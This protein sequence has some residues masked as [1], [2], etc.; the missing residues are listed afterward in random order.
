MI[1]ALTETESQDIKNSYIKKIPKKP[2]SSIF[3]DL[4]FTV[5]NLSSHLMQITINVGPE[6]VKNIYNQTIELYREN[7]TILEF[8][9]NK[10]PAEYIEIK[11][12]NEVF[13]KIK[14]FIFK[15]FVFDFLIYKIKELKISIANYPRLIR[16][17]KDNDFNLKFIF[18]LS[19]AETVSLKEWK[20]FIFRPPKR[21]KYK[22]LDKQVENFIKQESMINKKQKTL[23]IEEYDWVIF[24]ATLLD[25]NNK[26][27]WENKKNSF[28]I[29]INSKNL[30]CSFQKT[31]IGKNIDDTFITTNMP[32]EEDSLLD[33]ESNSFRFLIK[34][35]EI[36]KGGSFSIDLFKAAFKLKSKQDVHKKLIEAFSFKDDLSQRYSIIEELFH[37]LLSKHRFEI[38]AHISIR[39]QED[40]LLNLMKKPDFQVYRTQKE[41]YRQVAL[42]A[43]QQL[44]EEIL[45][46]QITYA[47]NI[48]ADENDIQNYLHLLSH[49]R[50]REFI[51]FKSPYEQ[52]DK[53]NMPINMNTL[54][55]IACREKTLNYII[56]TLTK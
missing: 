32:I 6:T 20:H 54:N 38:P 56:Y 13:E 39:R 4:T 11:H 3:S 22:D 18:D 29:K 53:T 44:K 52:L 7:S 17:I 42:L 41:F 43:E 55:Q 34:I 27:I 50:L 2:I 1:D 40:I 36:T 12:Q 51:H 16:I 24:D 14:I 26:Q 8:E 28:C 46:D 25:K 23:S 33:G 45:I 15:Y 48:M 21:K 31:L 37:L 49:N 35:R 9:K 19:V 10:T 30:T 47:E 5:K